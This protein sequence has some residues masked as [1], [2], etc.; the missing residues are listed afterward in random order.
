MSSNH[1]IPFRKSRETIGLV[2]TW[3]I[4]FLRVMSDWFRL[5][6][7]AGGKPRPSSHNLEKRRKENSYLAKSLGR[8]RS[9][10]S[11]RAFAV[12][13]SRAGGCLF[14]AWPHSSGTRFV[15]TLTTAWLPPFPRPICR[16]LAADCPK[17]PWENR[18]PSNY[19]DCNYILR[20]VIQSLRNN[21]SK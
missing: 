8:I 9:N 10:D 5:W 17:K 12:A 15:K 6:N 18:G 21:M 14:F 4:T 16:N 1:T 3:R 13:P 20:L 2:E 7:R 11:G 19:S